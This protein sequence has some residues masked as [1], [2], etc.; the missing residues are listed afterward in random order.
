MICSDLQRAQ[1]TA[2]PLLDLLGVK[3]VLEPGLREQSFGTVDG[4]QV[5]D[6]QRQFPD[7]WTQ[8]LRFDADYAFE[9]AESGRQFHQRVTTSLAKHLGQGAAKLVVVTHGGVLDMFYRH[10]MGQSLSGPRLCDIPNGGIN[11]LQ[12]VLDG[13]G[14][15]LT[16]QEWAGVSHLADLPPQPVYDQARLAREFSPKSA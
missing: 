12:A 16:V 2:K 8:W 3:C 11:R 9:G 7:A 15:R 1:Q 13:N 5:E 4:M 10:A 6:I 14:L